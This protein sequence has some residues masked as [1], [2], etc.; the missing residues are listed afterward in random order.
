MGVQE[1]PLS[2]HAAP[3]FAVRLYIWWSAVF[4]ASGWLLSWA[5]LLNRAGYVLAVLVG[6]TGSV[7]LWKQNRRRGTSRPMMALSWARWKR[8]LPMSY[9]VLLLLVVVSACL[10]APNSYDGLSYRIPRLL[11]WFSEGQWHWIQTADVRMNTRVAGTEWIWAPLIQFLRTDRWLF[12]PNLLAFVLLPGLTFATFTRMGVRPRVAW[13]WMWLVPTGYCFL[14][15]AGGIANDSYA[16]VFSLGGVALALMARQT[17]SVSDALLAMIAGAL[18]TSAKTSNLPLLLPIAVALW[19]SIR[20]MI[21]HF[22]PTAVAAAL[23]VLI[24]FLPTAILNHKHSGD[25]TGYTLENKGPERAPVPAGVASGPEPTKIFK[26]K[27]PLVGIAGNVANTSL[28]NLVPPVFPFASRWNANFHKL[29]PE[30]AR[31]VITQNFESDF[32]KLGELQTEFAGFGLGLTFLVLVAVLA[33]LR[34]RSIGH[35]PRDWWYTALRWSPFV[36]F[37]YLFTQCGVGS[38]ARL[39]A[40]YYPLLLPL[41]LAHPAQ[42]QLLQTRPW[43][44]SVGGVVALALTAL[45]LLPERPLWPAK[46]IINR[47]AESFPG[48][49]LFDRARNVYTTYAT[50]S[51]A[52]APLRA[53]LPPEV[54]VIGY[55]G[56]GDS[57]EASLWKPFGERRI[58]G[59]LP[60]SA[61]EAIKRFR[62]EYIVANA[63][64]VEWFFRKDVTD[65]C[66]ENR[67]EASNQTVLT[68]KVARGPEVWHVLRLHPAKNDLVDSDHRPSNKLVESAGQR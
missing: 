49:P 44:W 56:N 15:Q 39:V 1:S 6:A 7:W 50:R 21:R 54:N 31:A 36:S 16:A 47:L 9:A 58:V 59:I 22:F 3:L 42:R 60:Q 8:F 27:N 40:P 26:V 45:I 32:L 34:N 52:F 68:L 33:N 53:L 64:A 19:P 35:S 63:A 66:R 61:G 28:Q 30:E 10:Y 4:V 18:L 11:N 20:L 37:F 17:K 51:D 62:L 12:L 43:R 46:T 38:V 2:M 65:W 48:Q 29:L 55:I 5:G 41:I 24:S 23:G 14:L 25:W 67:C 57:P 13:T